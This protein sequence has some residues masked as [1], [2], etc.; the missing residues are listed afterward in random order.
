MTATKIW[1]YPRVF[2]RFLLTT[3]VAETKSHYLNCGEMKILSKNFALN[4]SIH[5]HFKNI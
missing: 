2:S 3:L 5:T 4:I 1:I